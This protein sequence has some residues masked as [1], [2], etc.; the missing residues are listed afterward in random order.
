MQ[1]NTLE[2]KIRVHTIKHNRN[3]NNEKYEIYSIDKT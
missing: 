2:T 3:D 1:I